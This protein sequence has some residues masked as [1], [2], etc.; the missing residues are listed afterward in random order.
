MPGLRDTPPEP[1]VEGPA[2]LVEASHLRF[3]RSRSLTY[4][5]GVLSAHCDPALLIARGD[6]YRQHCRRTCQAPIT[7]HL[8]QALEHTLK[9]FIRPY[10]MPQKRMHKQ[11]PRRNPAAPD[12]QRARSILP[13]ELARRLGQL[14]DGAAGREAGGRKGFLRLAVGE[15]GKGIVC[16]ELEKGR[17]V[18][19]LLGAS[20]LS[21]LFSA[22]LIPD[23]ASR[24]RRKWGLSANMRLLNI[25]A[26]RN[27]ALALSCF[28]F[29]TQLPVLR[30]GHGA[31]RVFQQR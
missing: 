21:C 5:S 24:G 14:H 16:V 18:N 6:D 10:P 8:L 15:G 1:P 12:K 28:P 22:R 23:L 29:A 20:A 26:A 11:H 3:A 30:A 9:P 19:R 17:V 27:L 2:G 13:S 25:P 7:R 31:S 4:W